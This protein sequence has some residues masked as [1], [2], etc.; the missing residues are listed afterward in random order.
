MSEQPIKQTATEVANGGAET[1]PPKK[2]VGG[3]IVNVV[4]VLAILFAIFISFTAYVSEAGSGLPTFFGYRFFSVQTDSMADEFYS[5]DL[6]VD[7]VIDDMSA[8]EVGDVITFWTVIDGQ[9]V[10]N[11]HR[12]TEIT[13]YEN[14]YYFTT[15]GDAN[16]VEDS[17]G[18]HENDIVGEYLFSISNLGTVVD[19]LTTGTGFLIVI[20]IPVFIFFIFQLV[21]FFKALFAYQREKVKLQMLEELAAQKTADAPADASDNADD[22]DNA[23]ESSDE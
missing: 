9:Q 11:S 21:A 5:G 17:V 23:D 7:S 8:L 13:D 15:K 6:I 12:I 19:F 20:V 16:T 2:K 3:I 4:L 14:Y 10:L 18:V 22:G 1:A